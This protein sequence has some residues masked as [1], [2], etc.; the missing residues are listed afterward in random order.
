MTELILEVG[1]EL[2]ERRPLDPRVHWLRQQFKLL[3]L[4]VRKITTYDRL[5]DVRAI[6]TIHAVG[7]EDARLFTINLEIL[8]VAQLGPAVESKRKIDLE[9]AIT[10]QFILYDVDELGKI[11]PLHL[12][13]FAME[14]KPGVAEVR[15]LHFVK[16]AGKLLTNHLLRSLL[17]DKVDQVLL[18]V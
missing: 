14:V 16:H 7:P 5:D 4:N 2:L 10:R 11:L 18:T 12:L 9:M 6:Q 8:W 3:K 15:I 17:V 1:W 13:A